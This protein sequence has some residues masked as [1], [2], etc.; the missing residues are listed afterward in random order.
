MSKANGD[1]WD[2]TV[3]SGAADLVR[4]AALTKAAEHFPSLTASPAVS[5]ASPCVHKYTLLAPLTEV[6][7]DVGTCLAGNRE[8]A[9]AF[10]PA[11]RPQPRR[12]YRGAEALRRCRLAAG[13]CG[14][15]GSGN[16]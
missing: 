6:G 4:D 10:D 7:P 2:R 14:R 15:G 16:H 3:A 13:G 12:H 5:Y 11:V 8:G 1:E 9:R